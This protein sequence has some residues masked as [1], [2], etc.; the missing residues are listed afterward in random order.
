MEPSIVHVDGTGVSDDIPSCGRSL[1]GMYV[2]DIT[3]NSGTVT[4]N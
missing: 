4:R 1:R 2:A 3:D